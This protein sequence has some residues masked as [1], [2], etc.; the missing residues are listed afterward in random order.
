MKRCRGMD[1]KQ[2][3]Y[4]HFTSEERPFVARVEDWLER[5]ARHREVCTP[6]LDP[7]QIFIV[8]S[9]AAHRDVTVY[10][11]GG[12]AQAER[13]RALMTPW[14]PEALTADD[15]G[16]VLLQAEAVGNMGGTVQH[17]HFLGSLLNTGIKRE[18][19]GDLWLVSTERRRMAQVVVGFEVADYLQLHWTKAG[20]TPLHVEKVPWDQLILPQLALERFVAMVASL[21]LDAF[22]AEVCRISRAKAAQLVKA[23]EVK[24]NWK[25][26]TDPAGPLHVGDV[27]AIRKYGRF[28]LLEI[29]GE[30]RKGR[31]RVQ[32]G[33]PSEQ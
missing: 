17:R 20:N 10:F 32:V 21:R 4:V 8:Q 2:G 11:H 26:E 19:I 16:L 25:V 1:I 33:K 15:F 31:L 7:R 23:Q 18:K 6:F 22:V 3:K 28:H 13:K 27:V 24:V 14:E 12:Y 29:Q 9:L 5:A 30:S